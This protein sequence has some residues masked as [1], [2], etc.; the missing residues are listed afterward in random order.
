LNLDLFPIALSLR[1][2]FAALAIAGPI[3]LALAWVQGRRRYA[4][5][6]LV[7]ALILMPLV[8]PPSVVGFFLVVGLGRRST[9]GAFLGDLGIELVFSPG[10]A[11]VAAAVVA[12]PLLVRTAQPAFEAVPRELE[13]VASTLGLPPVA[14]FLR[15][16]LVH[17]WRGVLAAFVLGFARALGEFGATLM[18]AGNIPGRTNT[19]PLEIYAAYQAGD[20]ERALAYVLV[21][22]ALSVGVALLAA[23]L[24]PE[25]TR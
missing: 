7:D 18:F 22:T 25:R 14:V 4:G 8:L 12:L 21:L 24:A 9:V 2:T 13:D 3:G 11:V 23:Q 10:G 5:H 1:V 6:R 19:T 17:A 20:D 16:T 15:V